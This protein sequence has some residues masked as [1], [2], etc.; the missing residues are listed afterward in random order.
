MY[1]RCGYECMYA[2]FGRTFQSLPCP[3]NILWLCPGKAACYRPLHFM[4]NPPHRIKVSGRTHGKTCLNYI[5]AEP[6]KLLC[7]NHLLL[8]IHGGTRRLL[9]VPKCCIKYT[10]KFSHLKSVSRSQ[11]QEAR[12]QSQEAKNLASYILKLAS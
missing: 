11:M 9:T 6:C 10:D 7:N 1:I 12:G 2:G 5:H 8:H 4:A 3:V